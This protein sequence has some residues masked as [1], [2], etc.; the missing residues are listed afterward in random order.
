M[1]SSPAPYRGA[2]AAALAIALVLVTR[3]ASGAVD[4]ACVSVIGD[5]LTTIE[6]ES[7]SARNAT[8]GRGVAKAEPG[9][10]R[11]KLAASAAMSAITAKKPNAIVATVDVSGPGS[12][13]FFDTPL[14]SINDGVASALYGQLAAGVAKQ[15]E[16]K[17]V[18]V[19]AKLE[20]RHWSQPYILSGIGVFADP[21]PR[22]MALNQETLSRR[23]IAPYVGA[24][25]LLFNADG[26]LAAA[27]PLA[28]HST[29]RT[30]QGKQ[31]PA[32]AWQ[33]LSAEELNGA[34]NQLVVEGVG[35]AVA[36]LPL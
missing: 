17:Q 26:K 12:E 7:T 25:L 29:Y 13:P 1:R 15:V 6:R 32:T 24:A 22:D 9:H 34:L 3:A 11:D 10:A 2:A 14:A 4:I 20:F 31:I 16:A 30:E 27:Q 21:G 33:I 19:I 18:I 36:R 23:Y 35:T 28:V 5:K 8:K